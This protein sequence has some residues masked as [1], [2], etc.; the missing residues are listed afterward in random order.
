MTKTK[1]CKTCAAEYEPD[2][3]NKM[4]LCNQCHRNYRSER[5]RVYY[6][7]KSEADRLR[8]TYTLGQERVCVT[9]SITFG[10]YGASHAWCRPCKQT[11]DKEFYARRSEEAKARRRAQVNER[12]KVNVVRLKKW[13]VEQGGCCRCPEN[14]PVCLDMHHIDPAEKDIELANV[15]GTWGWDKI[16]EEAAKCIVICANC[17]RKLH[18]KRREEE[19]K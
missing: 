15:V 16:M 13:K 10:H 11:Y 8:K 1:T 9:C 17:H 7:A 5:A 6:R 3:H 4:L 19:E 12:R 2:K 18:A 14:D